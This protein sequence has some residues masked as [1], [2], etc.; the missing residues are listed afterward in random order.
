MAKGQFVDS[1]DDEIVA[2]VEDAWPFVTLQAIN[3]FWPVRLTATDLAVVDGVRP[4]VPRLQGEAIAKA[5]FQRQTQGV[6]RA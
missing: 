2:D 6:I 3:V 1:V 5:A 4:G